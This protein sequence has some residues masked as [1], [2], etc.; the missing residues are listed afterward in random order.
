MPDPPEIL[1]MRAEFV[2]PSH[3]VSLGRDLSVPVQEFEAK[4]EDLL[5]DLEAHA[6]EVET[7]QIRAIRNMAFA[8]EDR[9][10][11]LRNL[12]SMLCPFYLPRFSS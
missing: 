11:L 10:C 1:P 4:Q 12:K 3:V 7:L 9:D 5:Q 6:A 8:R 2:R